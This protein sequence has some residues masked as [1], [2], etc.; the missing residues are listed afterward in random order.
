MLAARP[1]VKT[2][3]KVG[4]G[5]STAKV[6]RAYP[7]GHLQNGSWVVPLGHGTEYEFGLDGDSVTEMLL[8]ES[9]QPCTQ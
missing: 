7:T 9:T 5:S 2:P 6:Q 1:G 3:E 4:L 8:A